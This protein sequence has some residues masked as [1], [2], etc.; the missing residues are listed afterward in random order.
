M[1][2]GIRNGT[3]LQADIKTS[4]RLTG[5]N[6]VLLEGQWWCRIDTA[7]M[8]SERNT[9]GYFPYP[10]ICPFPN[11]THLILFC[12]GFLGHLYLRLEERQ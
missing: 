9:S 3:V 12:V 11:S 5:R 1:Y 6:M 2:S 4:G 7:G 10:S 8:S